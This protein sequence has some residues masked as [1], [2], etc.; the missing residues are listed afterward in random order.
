MRIHEDESA[1][2]MDALAYTRGA[3]VYLAP[4]H[5]QPHSGSGGRL[6]AH[7]M[8]HVIQ[9][10]ADRV[11]SVPYAQGQL[12]NEDRNLEQ[13]A[14]RLGRR[15]MWGLPSAVRGARSTVHHQPKGVVQPA[16]SPHG[17]M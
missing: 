1:T 14:D 13:E 3:D 4:G 8:V 5:Y 6:L 15:A 16:S 11:P 12:V 9:Q 2:A 10:R 17:S 7:E